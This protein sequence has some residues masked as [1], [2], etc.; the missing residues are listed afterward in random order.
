[1]SDA[2]AVRPLNLMGAALVAS[3]ALVVSLVTSV[4]VASRAY[5][6]RGE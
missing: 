5:L 3:V 6:G 1:M 2:V 4:V